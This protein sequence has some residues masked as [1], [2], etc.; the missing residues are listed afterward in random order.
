MP[1]RE[2]ET[3]AAYR[4]R[5]ES[6]AKKRRV[7][8]SGQRRAAAVSSTPFYGA[9]FAINGRTDELGYVVICDD[10]HRDWK[11]ASIVDTYDVMFGFCTPRAEDEEMQHD[12]NSR[13]LDEHVRTDQSKSSRWSSGCF[14]NEAPTAAPRMLR[15]S[16]CPFSRSTV[17]TRRRA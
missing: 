2:G 10:K 1:Q 9:E 13:G 7:L 15:S 6:N 5:L 17:D 12:A 4:R 8:T 11:R 14:S 3:L 16:T